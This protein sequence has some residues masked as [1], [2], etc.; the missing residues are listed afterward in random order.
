M[1]SNNYFISSEYGSRWIKVINERIS[2]NEKWKL[3]KSL[4][5]FLVSVY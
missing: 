3:L 4:I 2:F 1:D 5:I